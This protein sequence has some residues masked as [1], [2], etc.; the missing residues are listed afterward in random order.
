MNSYKILKELADDVG[1]RLC[2]DYS[3]R[4]MFGRECVGIVTDSPMH[5]IEKAAARGVRGF[6]TDNMGLDTIVYWPSVK[7]PEEM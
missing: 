3:G 7:K 2:S 6:R 1:G 5:V 4:G